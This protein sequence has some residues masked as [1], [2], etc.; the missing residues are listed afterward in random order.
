M[1]QCEGHVHAHTLPDLSSASRLEKIRGAIL[2]VRGFINL[3]YVISYRGQYLS[4]Y[5]L[6]STRLFR[7]NLT[8]KS[9]VHVGINR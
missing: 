5:N 3:Y 2:N 7:L 9:H 4:K 8:C 1:S 6:T